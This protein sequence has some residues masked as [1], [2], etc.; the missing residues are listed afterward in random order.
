MKR[1]IE[2]C[3]SPIEVALA[4]AFMRRD[5]FTAPVPTDDPERLGCV[6]YFE[7]LT[8]VQFGKYRCDF[9]L[10]PQTLPNQTG[11]PFVVIVEADGH[12]FHER[13]AEQAE[14]DKAR[15]RYMTGKGAM[16]FRFTGRQVW[17][18]ADACVDEVLF[19]ASQRFERDTLPYFIAGCLSGEID[20]DLTEEP[21]E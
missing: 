8:Q 3:E 9:A 17:R 12:A 10:N 7:I 16:V 14:R 11:Q 21:A 6:P 4:E 5:D 1:G 15:D 18:D 2:R 13:T 19:Y 20:C